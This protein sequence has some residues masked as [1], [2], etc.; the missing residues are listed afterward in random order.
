MIKKDWDDLVL[1]E[2]DNCTA[3]NYMGLKDA[4]KLADL[5]TKENI[6]PFDAK[7]F[8]DSQINVN[9]ATGDIKEL[10][11]VPTQFEYEEQKKS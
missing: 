7:N 11:C 6:F 10:L 5:S 9:I 2:D 8:A 1:E 4:H 3:T